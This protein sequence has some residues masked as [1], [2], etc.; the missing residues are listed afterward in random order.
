MEG[1]ERDLQEYA[2][3]RAPFH[4]AFGGRVRHL[5][6]EYQ[7]FGLVVRKVSDA[8]PERH[9]SYLEWLFSI[10]RAGQLGQH[11]DALRRML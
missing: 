5:L 3:E 6:D 4:E 9:M 2:K 7:R 8:P 11:F 1:T 10:G